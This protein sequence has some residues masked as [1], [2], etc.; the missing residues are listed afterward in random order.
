MRFTFKSLA[1]AYFCFS[2]ATIEAF[3]SSVVSIRISGVLNAGG[4]SAENLTNC[5]FRFTQNFDHAKPSVKRI[6]IAVV[7][8]SKEKYYAKAQFA[9]EGGAHL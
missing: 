6:I 1:F 7:T 9:A 2:A 4:K 8:I 5:F 3:F